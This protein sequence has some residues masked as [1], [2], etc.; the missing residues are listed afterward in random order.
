MTHLTYA[1]AGS[2]TNAIPAAEAVA[3]CVVMV[4][5]VVAVGTPTITGMVYGRPEAGGCSSRRKGNL[6]DSKSSDDGLSRRQ[7]GIPDNA[8]GKLITPC[9]ASDN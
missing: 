6:K 7:A 8:L 5:V 3:R 1:I 9:G 2:A 4:V